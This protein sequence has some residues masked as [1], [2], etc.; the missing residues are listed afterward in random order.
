MSPWDYM[1]SDE[2]I[3]QLKS[4]LKKY[5]KKN[6]YLEIFN[7]AVRENKI[8]IKKSENLKKSIRINESSSKNDIKD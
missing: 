6:S 5:Y 2:H 1:L 3:E 4:F 7:S 8:Y